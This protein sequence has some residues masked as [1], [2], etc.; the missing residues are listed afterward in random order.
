MTISAPLQGAALTAIDS[1]AP[2]SV[3]TQAI[4]STAAPAFGIKFIKIDFFKELFLKEH[5]QKEVGKA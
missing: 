3:R 2:R 5:S 4:Q 1:H